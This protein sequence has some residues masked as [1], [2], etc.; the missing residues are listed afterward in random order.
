MRLLILYT[1]ALIS[2]SGKVFGSGND[3]LSHDLL[4]EFMPIQNASNKNVTDDSQDA[5]AFFLYGTQSLETDNIQTTN[6]N[7][8][9]KRTEDSQEKNAQQTKNIEYIY[10]DNHADDTKNKAENDSLDAIINRSAKKARTSLIQP[11]INNSNYSQNNSQASHYQKKAPIYSAYHLQQTM[12]QKNNS[13]LQNTIA[14]NR[15]ETSQIINQS[16][17]ENLF[18]NVCLPSL[19]SLSTSNSIPV[20]KVDN[21]I[22][23]TIWY[24]LCGLQK[25]VF[26][27]CF[28]PEYT[29]D[30]RSKMI[31]LAMM[32]KGKHFSSGTSHDPHNSQIDLKQYFPLNINGKHYTDGYKDKLI[33]CLVRIFESYKLKEAFFELAGIEE[34]S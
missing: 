15:A 28:S 26:R 1:T 29:E 4:R 19:S 25:K 7:N 21:P 23:H 17:P 33:K 22:N 8:K 10:V 27:Y 2:I 11:N 34:N 18:G 30:R 13:N 3:D 14:E 9:R 6:Q 20:H 12:K 32:T 24:K 16:S 5:L 31:K